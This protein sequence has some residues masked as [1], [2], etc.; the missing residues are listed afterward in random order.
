VS[1]SLHPSKSKMAASARKMVHVPLFRFCASIFFIVPTNA[2]GNFNAGAY[3]PAS[4]N[5][6]SRA[7]A[8]SGCNL[9]Y[10]AKG[11]N[12]CLCSSGNFVT[13]SA[14]CVTKND[15]ADLANVYYTIAQACKVTNTPISITYDQFVTAGAGGCTPTTLATATS[16]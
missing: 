7:A 2:Q 5:F 4:Q 6:L 8:N 9:N 14:T 16:Q 12:T 11:M 13:Y 3:P 1:L 15:P 10:D